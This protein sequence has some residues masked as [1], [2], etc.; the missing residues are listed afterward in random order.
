MINAIEQANQIH[1]KI[2]CLINNAG[3]HPPNG[4]ID[5]FTTQNMRDLFE[6]NFISSFAACKYTLPHLR[7]THGNIINIA[8]WVG[9][10]G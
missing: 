5:D 1:G 8:S 2:D 10:H 7:K 4:E 3:W 9:T 6:L